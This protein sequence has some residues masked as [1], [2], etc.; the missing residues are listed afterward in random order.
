MIKNIE[1]F[2]KQCSYQ[3]QA[4]IFNAMNGTEEKEKQQCN[5]VANYAI[6][7]ILMDAFPAAETLRRKVL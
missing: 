2:R 3:P 1:C 4:L 5:I 7:T 6:V